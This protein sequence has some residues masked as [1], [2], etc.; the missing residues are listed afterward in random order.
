MVWNF[1]YFL[2]TSW[3]TRQENYKCVIVKTYLYTT[4]NICVRQFSVSV[5]KVN[6]IIFYDE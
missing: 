4:K 5:Q 6:W 3:W 2:Q 1:M